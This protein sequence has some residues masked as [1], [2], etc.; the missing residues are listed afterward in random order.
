MKVK[1]F[2]D[3]CFIC[4]AT[5]LQKSPRYFFLKQKLLTKYSSQKRLKYKEKLSC[6]MRFKDTLSGLR[7]FLST[8]SPL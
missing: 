6:K 2:T 1:W 5:L 4:K 8:E 3:L 7:Q